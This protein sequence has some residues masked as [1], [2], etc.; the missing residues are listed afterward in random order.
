MHAVIF[1]ITFRRYTSESTSKLSLVN[2]ENTG[3]AVGVTSLSIVES[4]DGR[5]WERV[6][7]RDASV[8]K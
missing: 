1:Q 7:G 5:E 4:A 8:R 3:E 6:A 2:V